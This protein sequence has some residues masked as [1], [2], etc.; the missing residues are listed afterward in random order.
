MRA[1]WMIA[2]LIGAVL[3]GG[4][5]AIAQG[6]GK[7]KGKGHQK[8]GGDD[9]PSS[10]VVFTQDE[11]QIVS[12]W[13]TDPRNGLPPGLAKKDRL[14]PGLEKQLRERGTLPPGLQKKIQPLPVALE[15]RLHPLPAGC[16]RVVI[17]GNVVIMNQKTSYVYSVFQVVIGR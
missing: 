7:G 8:N 15:H 4:V 17:G 1:R 16:R 13:Y 11:R 5:L 10:E 9:S 12:D 3:C 14:P 2:V 6:K